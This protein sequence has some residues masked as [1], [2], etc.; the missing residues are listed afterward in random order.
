[1]KRG[2]PSMATATTGT[3][4]RAK[5]RIK[6]TVREYVEAILLA[7]VL[8]VVIRGLVIQAF[9]IPS[10]SM[11]D[12]LLVGDFLFVN[13][14]VYG[15]E[16]D[17]GFGGNRV[18]YHRFPAVQGP[19]PGDL[20]VFRYPVDPAVVFIKA[21]FVVRRQVVVIREMVVLVDGRPAEES[22]A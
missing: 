12:T 17:I 7:V 14:M 18:V 5:A 16:I 3:T 13:K 6:S 4:M 22:Y 8:T 10:G 11:E 19:K 21:R 15:S 1:M 9:R 20:I 2:T